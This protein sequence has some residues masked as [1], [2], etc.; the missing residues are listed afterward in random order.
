MGKS[1]SRGA[2]AALAIAG[3]FL[4]AGVAAHARDLGTSGIAWQIPGSGVD[5]ERVYS[6]QASNGSPYGGY[7][8]D[9]CV[10]FVNTRANDVVGVQFLFTLADRQGNHDIPLAVD[11]RQTIPRNKVISDP[12]AT[13]RTYGYREERGRSLVGWVN[14]VFFADGGQW[15]VVPPVRGNVESSND[16]GIALSNAVTYL[17]PEECV[18]IT[19]ASRQAITSA[20]IAFEHVDPAGARLSEDVLDV[21]REISSGQTVQGACRK[22]QATSQPDVFAYAAAYAKAETPPGTPTI[23]V[24]EQPSQLVIR[25]QQVTFADGTLWQATL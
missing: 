9:D 15:R 5:V 18:D 22:F 19:N 3:V 8:T 24:R 7:W 23:V 20:R 4:A 14:A 21:K 6:F 10:T 1:N 2:G 13:C 17:P 11:I 16:S 25:V 12:Y